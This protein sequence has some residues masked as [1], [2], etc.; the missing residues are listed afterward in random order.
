MLVIATGVTQAPNDKEQVKPML[1]TLAAQAQTLGKVDCL[2]ADT[3][4][5]SERNVRAWRRPRLTP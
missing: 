4:F 5:F 3:G 1:E 2:L